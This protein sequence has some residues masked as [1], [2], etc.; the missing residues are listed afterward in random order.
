MKE[1]QLNSSDRLTVL[2]NAGFP[3][4]D[5]GSA[6]ENRFCAGDV[7]IVAACPGVMP[8]KRSANGDWY[9]FDF[10]VAADRCIVLFH[11]CPLASLLNCDGTDDGVTAAKRFGVDPLEGIWLYIPAI[12]PAN[13][14]G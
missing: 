12:P 8:T 6:A 14:A 2:S 10:A 5:D 1:Q 7:I 3:A 13:R 4:I 9:K 11:M